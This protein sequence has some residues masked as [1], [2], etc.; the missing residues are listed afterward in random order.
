MDDVR[1][2]YVDRALF[3]TRSL[4]EVLQDLNLAEIERAL[5]IE[6]GSRRRNAIMRRLIARAGHLNAQIYVEILQKR[7]NYGTS[8][9]R[10]SVR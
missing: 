10:R 8:T 3:S 2:W 4:T 6:S 1:K 5:Q 7:Y 9:K